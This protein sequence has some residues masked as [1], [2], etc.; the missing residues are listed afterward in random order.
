VVMLAFAAA[1]IGGFSS[2]AGCV[3]GGIF[4]GVMQNVVGILISPQ[5]M[6]V[7]PFF[8]IMLVLVLRPQGLF[9]ELAFKKV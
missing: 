7:T 5:A 6:A 4:L 8:V 9:G 3:I 2:L 1:I